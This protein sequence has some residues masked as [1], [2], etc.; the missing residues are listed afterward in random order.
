MGEL[1]YIGWL[2]AFMLH[3]AVLSPPTA[4]EMSPVDPAPVVIFPG[5]MLTIAVKVANPSAEPAWASAFAELPPSWLAISD[6]KPFLLGA[7]ET[8]IRLLTV[9]VPP[10]TRAGEYRV[11][12]HAKGTPTRP[13]TGNCTLL[14]QVAEFTKLEISTLEAPDYVMAGKEIKAKFTVRNLSNVQQNIHLRPHNCQLVSDDDISIPLD[15]SIIVVV[16]AN[17]LA[18]AANVYQKTMRVDAIVSGKEDYAVSAF[19]NVD[20]IPYGGGEL[21]T[22]KTLPLTI[23]LLYLARQKPNGSYVKGFQG[24]LFGKANLDEKGDHSVELHLRGP[25]RFNA[26]SIGFYE[27]YYA[28]YHSPTLKLFVGDKTYSLST[29]TEFARYGRGVEGSTVVNN[30]EIGGF[31]HIPRFYSEIKKEIAGYMRFHFDKDNRLGFNLLKKSYGGEEQD[32]HI[33][34]VNG[35]F[36]PVPSTQFEAELSSGFNG[37]HRSTAAYVQASSAPFERLSVYG[38]LLFA[39]KDFPGYYTNT[40]NYAG[41]LNYRLTKHLEFSS[42]LHQDEINAAYDTLFE[43]APFSRAAQVGFGLHLDKSR[44]QIR[45]F[46][47]KREVMDRMPARLF[48]YQINSGKLQA[49]RSFRD[50]ELTLTGEAG[51]R[52]NFV[53]PVDFRH[54]NDYRGSAELTW[55]ASSRLR[56]QVF[57]NY[58]SQTID[59]SFYQK[60]WIYGID[61]SGPVTKSTTLRLH[62]QNSFQIEDYFR[63]RSL[64]ELNLVQRIG[65]N[66]EIALTG[67]YTLLQR[68]K[69]DKDAAISLVYTWRPKISLV[70]KD[71]LGTVTGFIKNEGVKNTGNIVVLLNGRTTITDENGYF[72]FK[73]IPPGQYFLMPDPSTTGLHDVTTMD[74]PIEVIVQAGLTNYVEFGLAEGA[75][76]MGSINLEKPDKEVSLLHDAQPLG[77]V[78]LELRSDTDVIR[79]VTGEDG[80]FDFSD[81]RPGHY[82]LRIN[83]SSIPKNRRIEKESFELELNSGEK[84]KV[85]FSIFEKAKTIRYDQDW[86]HLGGK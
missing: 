27:E 62:F 61:G 73:N 51:K 39:G 48:H 16:E 33:F 53:A 80:Q 13:V 5:K 56:F 35:E 10:R 84:K 50:F 68:T 79:Q 15:S 83:K 23:R 7:G 22:G 58:L 70:K 4:L 82:V 65:R 11:L 28:S 29:L 75:R 32:A 42:S 24:E 66:H 26:S 18:H 77:P 74:L 9:I 20:V 37:S 72:E 17:T 52:T 34:S 44:V 43:T 31:Y 3:M 71:D 49:F 12:Y 25:D 1:F 40:L 78:L 6:D 14:I 30:I 45:G 46:L 86:L 8:G 76:I 55:R 64:A 59:S 41:M 36:R 54:T 2:S 85:N 47:V 81:L 38:Q 67:R 60:E 69:E 57:T 21:I 63:N 19:A